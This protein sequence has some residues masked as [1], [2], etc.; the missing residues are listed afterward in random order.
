MPCRS[1]ARAHLGGAV[2]VVGEWHYPPPGTSPDFP[3]WMPGRSA[4]D[5]AHIWLIYEQLTQKRIDCSQGT[6]DY[7]A[8]K[9]SL[10][11]NVKAI[12]GN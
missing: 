4:S 6:T 12:P 1:D 10:A 9:A 8:A 11:S 5:A 3:S 7:I 2:E